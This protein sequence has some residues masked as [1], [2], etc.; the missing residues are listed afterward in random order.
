MKITVCVK[1]CQGE[2][3]PFDASALE[4]ALRIPNAEVS[5]LTMS[6]P[7]VKEALTQLTRLPISEIVML[8]D[9]AFAGSDTLATS[10]I[11]AEYLKNNMPDLILCGRQSIDG[12]TAQVGWWQRAV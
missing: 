9:S 8:C 2:M 5:V 10:Y 3:N 4:Y 11:L 7:S 12:D 6:P 1:Y